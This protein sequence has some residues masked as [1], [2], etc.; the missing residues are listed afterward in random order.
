MNRQDPESKRRSPEARP[1]PGPGDI[2]LVAVDLDGTLLRS[3][4]KLS[5]RVIRAVS[6]AKAKGV[7]VVLASARPPR[8][9]REIYDLLRL[10]TL[11]I[12][13]NGAVI[14]DPVKEQI[15]IHR[16]IPVPL[17]RQVVDMAREMEQRLVVHVEVLDR[18]YTDRDDK[19]MQTETSR[20]MGVDCL[21][22]LARVLNRPVT[23]LMLMGDPAWLDP[24]RRA[25]RQNFHG[26]LSMAISD[27]YLIQVV[28]PAADKAR[29]L[30][31]IAQRY[32]IPA[33]QVMALGDA[34]NDESM[35]KWA[36]LGVAMGNAWPR[37]VKV[38]DCTVPS[39]D[40]DGVAYAIE[41]FILGQNP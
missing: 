29:A 1:L 37:T 38:A 35:L 14:F 18:L 7:R 2:R 17:A 21:G 19:L 22:P 5:Y 16:P 39:N 32:A 4:K 36:G 30:Q 13:Y 41:K 3:D 11:Q 27:D 25:I 33:G 8:S 20:A 23:K 12:N 10:D 24:I 15:L 28:H 6:S 40:S 31:E 34:P 26:Q 9:V